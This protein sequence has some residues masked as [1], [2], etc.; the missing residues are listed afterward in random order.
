[1]NSRKTNQYKRQLEKI[2]DRVGRTAAA[3]EEEVRMPLGGESAGGMSNAPLHLGD[4]GTHAF[5]QELDTTLLENE[6]YL[7]DEAVAALGRID[8]GTFGRCTSCGGDVGEERL[9]AL[10]YVRQCVACAQAEQSGLPVNVNEGR[11][12][13][14][15]G[16]P[17]HEAKTEKPQRAV[18]RDLGADPTDVHAAGT[19]GGGAAVGGL[20]GTTVGD[21]S[22][23]GANLQDAMGSGPLDDD[24][25]EDEL[26]AEAGSSG[27]AVGGTPANKRA[28]GAARKSRAAQPKARAKKSKE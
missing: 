6:T 28:G 20:A 4:L 16:A 19:P 15:L 14:W 21:G 17:G 24:T 23:D 27:G 3:L 25:D 18:G 5:S 9:D 10:P 8:D 26:P 22:P 11:P 2:A 1:M 7:R 12:A 13:A